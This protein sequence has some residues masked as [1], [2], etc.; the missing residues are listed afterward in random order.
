[1]SGSGRSVSGT[2]PAAGAVWERRDVSDAAGRR[3]VLLTAPDASAQPALSGPALLHCVTAAPQVA[4]DNAGRPRLSLTVAL[5][6]QPMPGDASLAPLIERGVCAMDLTAAPPP[7]LVDYLGRSGVQ[8]RPL[9]AQ[10]SVYRLIAGG[11]ATP[12]A[13]TV[14]SGPGVRASLSATLDAAATREFLDA[15]QGKRGTLQVSI[16]LSYRVA[17]ASRPPVRLQADLARVHDYLASV[18][19]PERTFFEAELRHYLLAMIESGVVS[20]AAGGASATTAELTAELAARALAGFL[21]AAMPILRKTGNG[22]EL[23]ASF[24]LEARPPGGT[25][26]DFV[27]RSRGPSDDGRIE[28]VAD[29][30]DVV[31]GILSGQ[32]TDAFLHWVYVGWDGVPQP[33]PRLVRGGRPRAAT[34]DRGAAGDRAVAEERA[35]RLTTLG[36]AASSLSLAL[37]PSAHQSVNLHAV[38]ASD[39]VVAPSI[40]RLEQHWSLDDLVIGR[41]NWLPGSADLRNLPVIDN[42]SAVLWRD[43]VQPNSYWFAP[44]LLPVTPAGNAA[45]ADSP[46]LFSFNVTG[47]DADG[48]PGLEATIRLTLARG[49]SEAT[50]AEWARLGKPTARPVVATNLSV[51]LEIPFRDENGTTRRQQVSAVNVESRGDQVVAAFRLTDRWARLCYGAL[52]YAG[53]QAEPARLVASYSFEAYVPLD[54]IKLQTV[55]GGKILATPVVRTPADRV[56]V[57]E[58]PHVDARTMAVRLPLGELKLARETSRST[59]ELQRNS[60]SPTAASAVEGASNGAGGGLAVAAPARAVAPRPAIAHVLTAHPVALSVHATPAPATAAVVPIRPQLQAN[61]AV[62]ALVNQ[63]RF[64]VRTQGRTLRQDILFPCNQFGALYLQI[65]DGR[66]QAIGCQEAYK[67]GQTE[68]KLYE[69]LVNVLETPNPGFRLFRSL[70][71]PGRFLVVPDYYAITRFEPNQ[72]EKAY[73]PTVFLYTT[74]DAENPANSRCV[75]MATLQAALDPYQRRRLLDVLRRRHHASPILEYLTELPGDLTY[76][77]SIAE[78][79]GPL[80]LQPEA[81]RLWDSFQVSLAVDVAGVPQLQALLTHGGLHARVTLAL[82]DRTSL[83]TTLRLDLADIVGPWQSGPIEMRVQGASVVARNRIERPVNVRDLLVVAGDGALQTLPVDRRLEPSGEWSG[84]L[85]AGAVEALPVFFPERVAA[86]LPEIRSFIEDIRTN[87]VFLNLLNF[88]NHNLVRLDVRARI[89]GLAGE[90]PLKLAETDTVGALDFVLPLTQYL[91]D[92]VLQ[93]QVTRTTTAGQ[94]TSSAWKDWQLS[95]LGNVVGL[96]WELVQ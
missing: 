78:G 71:T 50:K 29:L 36:G 42:A 81:A 55:H 20:V 37:R 23:G 79:N 7:E 92:P 64:G 9:F 59:P 90:S 88:A 14:L 8:Y 54:P 34:G 87:V 12:I 56:R 66:Q 53:F 58:Q 51:G 6:R 96:T 63:Q 2:G 72:G 39:A 82:A 48:R 22:G 47:H 28:L 3:C 16:E 76:D 91:A 17:G 77:W 69:E 45:P 26:I 85:P 84:T 46:F 83:Q 94:T 30:T 86:T 52:A 61:A 43:R 93:F 27:E 32:D 11:R 5:S 19:G 25:V 35:A 10:R 41:P 70:Q 74:I 24:K 1:M 89:K 80:R 57:G 73:R 65:S 38:T 40:H 60:N 18:T 75:V 44:E 62:L 95:R 13:E 4:C 15:L 68:F 31:G 33:V 67:L 21:R 49:M